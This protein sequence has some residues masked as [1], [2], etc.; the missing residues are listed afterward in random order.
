M[1]RILALASLVVLAGCIQTPP[2]GVLPDRMPNYFTPMGN[3][4]LGDPD[5]MGQFYVI[6]RPGDG[7]GNYWCAA[8]QYVQIALRL[9]PNTRLYVQEPHHPS[10]AGQTVVTFTVRPDDTVLAA[11]GSPASNDISL[12]VG[13]VGENFLT[14]HAMSIC[15]SIT[16]YYW[17]LDGI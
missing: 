3:R 11:A 4:V 2:S 14:A 15:R 13:N 17:D 10:P 6:A 1:T 9:P 5:V 7:A 12:G 8:G 16:P